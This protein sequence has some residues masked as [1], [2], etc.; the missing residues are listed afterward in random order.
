MSHS[1]SCYRLNIG[2]P[3]NPYVEALTSNVMAMGGGA[4]GGVIGW[5]RS[6][7]GGDP[8]NETDALVRGGDT[9]AP[10]PCSH[11]E[12]RPHEGTVRG[13]PSVT[14]EEGLTRH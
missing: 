12:D 7:E 13:Q 4:L 10:S 9:G 5:R 6:H 3:Q 8:H 11:T 1:Q 2:V 14:Q